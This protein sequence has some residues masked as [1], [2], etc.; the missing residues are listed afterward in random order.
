[1]I[2]IMKFIHST[3][4]EFWTCLY[5]H[6]Y[7][8]ILLLQ[9]L[10]FCGG[11][12]NVNTHSHECCSR[13]GLHIS[14]YL[15]YLAKYIH[16]RIFNVIRIYTNGTQVM[17]GVSSNL[18]KLT[19]KLV[20]SICVIQLQESCNQSSKLFL[21]FLDYIAVHVLLLWIIKIK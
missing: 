6:S 7:I 1:M 14:D 12:S 4:C 5:V 10:K 15:N 2:E 11:I 9:P 20:K 3:L 19:L 18:D 8:Y 13:K 21:D 16:Q 17:F